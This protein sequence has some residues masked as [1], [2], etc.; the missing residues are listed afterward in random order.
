M[1]VECKQNC[2]KYHNHDLDKCKKR[3]ITIDS[4]NKCSSFEKGFIY[5]FY[6]VWDAL[7]SSNYIDPIDM[8][9]DYDLRIGMFYVAE[10]FHLDIMR[11]QHGNWTF[12]MFC[13]DNSEKGLRY[14]EITEG[15]IDIDIM[16]KYYTDFD[17]GILPE[18]KIIKGNQEEQKRKEFG[19]LSPTGK[20]IESP[21]GTHEKRANEIIKQ[22]LFNEEFR[23]WSKDKKEVGLRRDF[24]AEVKGYALIHNPNMFSDAYIVTHTKPLT[25]KQ[26]DF[27]FGY[28]ADMEDYEMAQR[29][30][31]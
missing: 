23:K 27:L 13:K 2:C 5:Y 18:I 20:F 7:G 6:L 28:F 16:L 14:E 1:Q 31:D 15:E 10:C 12:Y 22:R 30:V 26:K 3:K 9:R 17:K 24:L 19:W 25:R 29:Y 4:E 21:F 8:D 11:Y